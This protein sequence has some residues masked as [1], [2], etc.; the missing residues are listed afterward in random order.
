MKY[1]DSYIPPAPISEIVMRNVETGDRSA[2]ERVLLDTGS[3]ISLIAISMLKNLQ[4]K[5]SEEK[6]NLFGFDENKS[7]AELYNLQIIFLGKRITGNYCGINNTVGILGRDILNDFC[8]N[9]DGKNLEWKE[10]AP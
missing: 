3:D 1:D 5:P 9:F 10:C 8:I 7:I 6:V 2:K 4:I